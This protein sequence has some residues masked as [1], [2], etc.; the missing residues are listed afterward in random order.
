MQQVR[1]HL[2]YLRKQAQADAELGRYPA[3]RAL[4]AQ[5]EEG[6]QKLVAADPKNVSALR[7]LER[8]QDDWAQCEEYASDPVTA[9]PYA[10]LGKILQSARQHLQEEASTIRQIIRKSPSAKQSDLQLQSVQVRLSAVQFR[11]HRRAES[12]GTETLP[13]ALALLAA[14]ANR[15]QATANDLGSA[16]LAFLQVGSPSL[17]RPD[18]A[19]QWAQRAVTLTHRRSPAFLLLL[20]TAY[21]ADGEV[22][23]AADTAR[24]GLARLPQAPAPRPTSHLIKML[25]SIAAHGSAMPESTLCL[26]DDAPVTPVRAAFIGPI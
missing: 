15:S 11:L 9:E 20:A 8:T 6:F 4:F 24:E 12:T 3:A 26:Q 5:A 21:Q 19:V 2:V 10:G 25:Q 1:L 18:L 14:A 23:H 17:R 13:S 7:D 22:N 16:A